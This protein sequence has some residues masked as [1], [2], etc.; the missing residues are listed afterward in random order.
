WEAVSGRWFT[1]ARLSYVRNAA[2]GVAAGSIQ[3]V[4]APCDT[5]LTRH[6][7]PP[8]SSGGQPG[9]PVN[10]LIRPRLFAAAALLLVLGGATYWLRP[11]APPTLAHATPPQRH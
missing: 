10:S 2:G 3:R 11:R 4:R 7:R 6:S 8:R 9:E 1:D 5:P